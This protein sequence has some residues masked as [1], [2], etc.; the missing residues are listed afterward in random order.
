M[1]L[2]SEMDERARAKGT[3]IG[4]IRG[5]IPKACHRIEPRRS[6]TALAV[7]LARLAFALGLLALVRPAWGAGLAWRI[8]A[9]LAGWLFAGWC[10]TG[11]FVIGHDCGHLAFSERRWVNVVVGHLC[12]S[13]MFTGFHNW[14]IWHNYHHAKTQLRGQDPD[15]PEKMMTRA[16]YD[17][18]PLGEKAHVWFGFGTPVG[19]L[20][21]FWSGV[22]RRTFMK[23]LAPQI[24][25]TRRTERDVLVSSL[26][27]LATCGGLTVLLYRW[28]GA[29]M[30]LKYYYVPV[31]IAATHGSML[32]YL[33]H[34]NADA[35][36]FDKADWTPFRGQ[37]ASTFNVRF[38]Q[39]IE[40]LW[41]DINIHLVHHLAPRIP[42]YHLH[43][44]TEAIRAVDPSWVQ[45]RRFSF[46]Y[47]R[48]SWAR[49]LLARAT[50]GDHFEMAPF[51]LGGASRPAR[52]SSGL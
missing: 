45:E 5:A 14:R 34:T 27:M 50:A 2:P 13:S 28:G 37:V 36:V 44:A 8:P 51:G 31:F 48:A 33:H 16:E 42:W 23:T 46:G 29:W 40:A 52:R 24:P 4:D 20:V 22:L 7:A 10:F 11:L 1:L 49:P 38:P 15:W 9:L 35:L 30:L 12:T 17:A 26:V 18:A 41:F 47:L 3:T 19:L 25:L 21:G 32:T 6:W 39:W 43:A